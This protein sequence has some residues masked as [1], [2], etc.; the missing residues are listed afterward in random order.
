MK[1]LYTL[2]IIA[3]IA[4]TGLVSCGDEAVDVETVN[5]QTILVFMP[6][7]GDKSSEGLKASL[8][9]NL[10][11]I[12]TAIVA[13][14]GLNRSRVVVF[15][16]TK[17]GESSLYELKYNTEQN[18]VTENLLNTYTGNDYTT[19]D[20]L[21]NIIREVKQK[22]EALN[23]AMIIGSHGCGWTY[24]SDWVS[25]PYRSIATQPLQYSFSFGDDPNHPITRMFG[26]VSD[27]NYGI[28][29]T[30]LAKAIEASDTKMQYIL[31]DVCYMSNVE[32]AY[33]L[34]NATNYLLASS[35][36]IMAAGIPYK[37][38]WNMINSAAPN[39]SGIVSTIYSFYANSTVPYV[40]FAATDCRQMEKLAAVMKDINSKYK[41][42]ENKLD[43]VQTLDGFSPCLFYDLGNYVD[44]LNVSGKLKED[45]VTQLQATVKAAQS[46]EQVY[47]ALRGRYDATIDVKTFCGLTISDPSTHPAA[48][49]G[50]EKTAWWAATH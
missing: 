16:S 4:L 22:A 9:Q 47:T 46:T 29:V 20:G 14:K 5:Q 28:D 8:L 24:T 25:Y 41:F 38:I 30:T 36:E 50:R 11:S 44:I 37:L 26:S 39:Y 32:T 21:A 48:T 13:N 15:F 31:F 2:F 18:T 10:D 40:N 3:I 45:F 1:K 49:K 23:Y 7:S 42:D 12:K 43:S 6:W 33:E 19:A 17:Y 27:N 34:R 35:S